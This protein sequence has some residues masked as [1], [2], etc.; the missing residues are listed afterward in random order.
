MACKKKK[1]KKKGERENLLRSVSDWQCSQAEQLKI[2][3]GALSW[4][5]ETCPVR[6]RRGAILGYNTTIK[7]LSPSLGE[8]V[9]P[10]DRALLYINLLIIKIKNKQNTPY[11]VTMTIIVSSFVIN[12][13]VHWKQILRPSPCLQ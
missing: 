10:F 7:V 13:V 6:E 4:G 9:F 2:A 1:G 3:A 8:L 11:Q 12:A 5:A